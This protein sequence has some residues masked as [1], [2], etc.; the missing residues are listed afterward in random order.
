MA[1]VRRRR[2]GSSAARTAARTRAAVRPPVR[3]RKFSGRW[4]LLF[5][6]GDATM[7]DLLGG[8]GAGLAEMSR[9]GLP[10]PPGFTITTEACLEYYRRDRQFPPG[11]MDEVRQKMRVL[12]ERTGRRFGDP[13]APLLVSVRSGAKFSMPGMMDTVLNLGLN[14]RT[15]E[16]LA[17]ATG[18][19]RF[20]YDSYRR[21]MQMFGNVVLGI[22]HELFEQALQARKQ[23]RGVTQDVDLT[24]DDLAALLEDYRRIVREQTGRDFPD[25]P[26]EQLEMAIRAVFESWN[27]PRAVTYRTVHRIPHDLGTAVNVQVMVFGNLGP[28]SGTGV[29]FTRNPATGEKKVYGEYLLNAQGED[30]VAGLRTPQPIENLAREMPDVHRQFLQVCELLERHYRDVQDVEFTIENG[31]LYLLQ[32]RSGKRTAQAAVKIAV[33]MVHEGLISREEALLRVEPASLEQLLHPRLD[34]QAPRRVIGRGLA[35]SPGAASGAVVFDADEAVRV[36]AQRPVILVRPETSPDDIHGL[37]AAR[38]VLTS[39]GG[40]TSHAAI[41]AR[42]MGKPAVVGAEGVRIDE[43]ARLFTSG[44]VVVREGDVIT[45]D[46]STGEVILGEVPV[47]EPQLTGEIQELLSWADQVRRL[48]VRANADYPRDARTAVEFGAEGIGLC[49]TEHMFMEEDR[50]PIMQRMIMAATEEERRAALDQLLVFQKEDFKGIFREMRN[51]PVIIR[52]LDPPLHEFLPRLEDLLV[53]VTELRLRGDGERLKEKEA[54][55]HRVRALHEFNPMLGL[56]GCRLGILYPE[57]NEMQVRAILQA[58][59]ELRREEGVEVI[60]EIMIPLVGHPNELRVVRQQLEAIARQMVEESGV[61]VRYMFGT[62][63]EIPRACLVAD[64]IAELAE[65]FSFGTND[66]T[67]TVF[68]FSRDDAQAKFL[69]VYLQKGILS[70]DPFAVLDQEGVGRLM[71][72]ATQ[73]GRRRRPDLEVGICGEHGGEP[74]SVEFCHRIGLDYVSCSP[75][76]VPVARLAAAHAALR[77]KVAVSRDV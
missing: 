31:R 54:L 15:C 60:P 30:V 77:E 68:G 25:D 4:T 71:E 42:G 70:E 44:D 13:S 18:N 63:I 51:R 39:R 36:A 40:M 19:P 41:V 3:R 26:W 20:A 21:F 29:A 23:A 49:R 24:A 58:A 75:Y 2:S 1:E 32:T 57:I 33:D 22:K 52:L 61:P 6:E 27:N 17:R 35:A 45:I 53:E 62:M 5:E 12:E 8:K 37:V 34:P 11:L 72:M 50:L 67:Q 16:G 47:I 14:P 64:Q 65:F 56:R 28:T 73:L 74:S 9:I 55:L 66:L 43:H 46:G 48:G 69:H 10:V 59:I 38:G 7:R 76:R